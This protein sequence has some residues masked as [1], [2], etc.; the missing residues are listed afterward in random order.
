MAD[1]SAMQE[2]IEKI[3]KEENLNVST[4]TLNTKDNTDGLY[5]K[6]DDAAKKLVMFPTPF[7]Q[8]GLITEVEVLITT[9]KTPP[10]IL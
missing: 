5:T 9:I 6:R 4:S 10:L 2:A 7:L 1:Y 8:V 3:A